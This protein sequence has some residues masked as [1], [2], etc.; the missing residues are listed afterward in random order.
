[1]P[2]RTSILCTIDSETFC[3]HEAHPPRGDPSLKRAN[4]NRIGYGLGTLGG[5]V[6][7]YE[8]GVV[9][10]ALLFAA[11]DL[12]MSPVVTGS[13]V[14]AALL[15]SI[16]GALCT[17]PISDAVG[18]RFMIAAAA[19]IFSLGII[20]AALAPNVAMLIASRLILGFAV[21]IAT[22]IVPI[23][24]AEIAPAQGRGAF[25]GL[26]QVMIYAGVLASSIVGMLL[27]PYGDW[28]W[29][30][31]IGLLPALVMLIGSFFLPESPRWLVKKGN[32]TAAREVLLRLRNAEGVDAELEGIK[33]VLREEKKQLSLRAI[34]RSPR[35]RRLVI[36][37]S[38]LGVLQQL[39]G[40]N[41]VTYYAPTVLKMIGFSIKNSIMANLVFSALGLLM[42]IVMAAFIVDK[43]GRRIP[44]MLGAL[45]MAASMALLGLIF[46]N[47]SELGKSGYIAIGCLAAFQ[48]SFALSW[49]GMVWIVLG[50]M[51]P[52]SAR[53]TAMGI[54]V[55]MAE[56]TSVVV[57]TVFPVLLKHGAAI[58]FF[59]FAAM[60]ILAFFWISLMLPETKRRSL[61]EI[62]IELLLH[63]EGTS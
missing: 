49:G 62:E 59:G 4:I 39:I 54:S 52:L 8:L 61:E 17:G 23:Y 36:I 44:L 9:A 20:G 15:G 41:A 14:S 16:A 51:F 21:G 56:A 26:F 1:M 30:F 45:V 27:A 60:G 57:G 42:T 47:P 10:A 7:G 6:R 33:T 34:L 46:L 24:I 29:M 28:R 55:F 53:G 18:R 31:A 19:I 13:V 37:G 38:G 43:M 50:E 58:I 48:T 11:P 5:G 35:L 40:I 3:A 32:E 63:E 22:V 12:H 2:S 25:T